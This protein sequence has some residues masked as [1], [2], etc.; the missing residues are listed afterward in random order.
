LLSWR[1]PGDKVIRSVIAVFDYYREMTTRP[2]LTIAPSTRLRFRLMGENDADLVFE[3]DQDPEVMRFL[4]DGKPTP[5]EEV[6]EL[7]IPRILAFTDP[8]AGTG[9]WEMAD[10]ESGEYLG[11][12]LVRE[13]GFGTDYHTPGNLELGWRLKRKYWG[14]GLTTEAAKAIVDVV[15]HNPGVTV[16]SSLADIDN[17]ASIWVMKNL[18]MHFVDNRVHKGPKGDMPVVYYEMI[19][20]F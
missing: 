2:K 1:A 16:F 7:H 19:N 17:L 11:W 15:R 18:G 12:I 20:S 14:Q 9:L 10:R 3:L 6:D 5:R 13:Y 8:V 4:N